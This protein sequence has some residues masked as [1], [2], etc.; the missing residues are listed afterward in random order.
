MTSHAL[1]RST[2]C[3]CDMIN[4]RWFEITSA[5][6]PHNSPALL[7]AKTQVQSIAKCC[8]NVLSSACAISSISWQIPPS[9]FFSC[10]STNFHSHLSSPRSTLFRKLTSC[11]L[12]FYISY[13]PSFIFS[14][15]SVYI[16]I[17]FFHYSFLPLFVSFSFRQ[18]VEVSFPFS[19]MWAFSQVWSEGNPRGQSRPIPTAKHCQP[20]S[21]NQ[22]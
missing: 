19:S 16:Y 14:L 13:P 11:Y 4:Y 10:A 6:M 20:D 1:Y 3:K 18:C 7:T 17:C 22:P 15:F 12:P 8:W 5:R 21:T 2:S 9:C